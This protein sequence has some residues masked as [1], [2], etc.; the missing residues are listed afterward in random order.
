[1][2]VEEFDVLSIY[3]NQVKSVSLLAKNKMGLSD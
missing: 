1:M 2:K 3:R